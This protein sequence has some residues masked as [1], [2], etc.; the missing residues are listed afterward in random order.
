MIPVAV[1]GQN[2]SDSMACRLESLHAGVSDA[3]P[4]RGE[5]DYPCMWYVGVPHLTT[6]VY[7]VPFTVASTERLPKYNMTRHW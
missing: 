1:F 7:L 3:T 4:G 6:N 5:T 2:G